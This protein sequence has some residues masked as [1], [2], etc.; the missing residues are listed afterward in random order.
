[1]TRFLIL[2]AALLAGPALAHHPLG[3]EAPQ[4][5]FHGLVSGLAH[6]VIGLDHL[7]FV[8]LM[9]LAAA[10]AG[11]S[12]VGPFA[13][14]AATLAGTAVHLGGVAL[15]LAELV[16]TASVVA[17]GAA[18]VMGRQVAGRVALAAFAFAGI[19]HGWA[20]GEAVVGST[21]MPIF[22]YLLGFGVIQ[23]AI[24]AGVALV[25]GRMLQQ[26]QGTFQARLAAAVCMGVG[27][28]FLFET[29]EHMI[30]G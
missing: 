10:L 4:T 5:V 11:R 25:A 20:Y 2:P 26:G 23:F 18:L 19:F 14:I 29:A 21:P 15:P 27:L 22:A 17:L 30:L 9:G 16:I 7:A 3:G 6:P 12:L 1:M 13:F 8:V 24:A 28:A